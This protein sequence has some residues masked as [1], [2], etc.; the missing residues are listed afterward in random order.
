MLFKIIGMKRL[1][2]SVAVLLLMAGGCKK[3]D[4]VSVPE[5]QT[6]S[7]QALSPIL[8]VFNGNVIGKGKH[9]ILDYGFA[10]SNNGVVDETH[11]TKVSL[12][13]SVN[14][15]AFTK[16]VN[17]LSFAGNYGYQNTVY[18]RAYVRD[19]KGT[20]FGAMISAVLPL[21]SAGNISP[22]LGKSGEVVK[23]SGNFY[24]PVLSTVKVAFQGVDAKVISVSD[25]EISA[26]IPSGINARH[27]YQVSVSVT[28]GNIPVV[29]SANF[30]ILAN[31]KDYSP[32][33][34]PIGTMISFSGDNLLPEYSN[35]S[36][37]QVHFGDKPASIQ[38]G[39]QMQTQVPSGISGNVPVSITFDGQKVILPGEFSVAVPAITKVTPET[40]MPGMVLTISGTNLPT[41]QNPYENN[42]M[43]KLGDAAYEAA[44][45]DYEGNFQFI[46]PLNTAA[47]SYDLVMKL[48]GTE[49]AAPGK[50]TVKPYTVTGFSPKSGAPG[51]EVNIKGAFIK[52]NNYTVYFGTM[53][54]GSIATSATNL[55]VVVPQ[56]VN[57]GKVKLA[58]DLPGIRISA[59][60]EFEVKGPSVTSFSPASGVAGAI[61]TIKG[62]GFY[63]GDYYTLVK[64]GT[65]T[66]QAIK[67][68]ENTITVAVPSNLNIGEM[69]LSIVT[70][71]QEVMASGN[72]TATN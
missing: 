61:I 24:S 11:G 4:L 28:I 30:T 1:F 5:V 72:F 52:D 67:T 18:V 25:T 20:A 27:G 49:L 40:V 45:Y 42:P 14:E 8:V 55:S 62:S 50:I 12:G 48:G 6:V 47:G 60:G 2:L 71:G 34:G 53:A 59:P 32:K 26:E 15:G 33:S 54:V 22:A 38:Y 21:P 16:T 7:V 56:G 31:V 51:T 63:P 46:V 13:S 69:K 3:D 64:F 57:A 70:G 41:M 66:I 37:F 35:G 17:N 43:A 36:A 58:V 19:E 23:I 10:Y 65:V 29:M 44:G 39:Y 68:T 9:K